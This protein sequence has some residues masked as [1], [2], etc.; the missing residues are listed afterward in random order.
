MEN[1]F[2]FWKTGP[3]LAK[4]AQI[5]KTGSN[6]AKQGQMGPSR[7]S[8]CKNSAKMGHL[9][10]NRANLDLM[11]STRANWSQRE[12]IRPCN[13]VY[14][15]LHDGQEVKIQ[16]RENEKK[17]GTRLNG[18]GFSA[19]HIDL[20]RWSIFF[21]FVRF[22]RGCS[23]PYCLTVTTWANLAKGGLTRTNEV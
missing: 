22:K 2:F 5:G 21:S 12:S 15:S 19:K 18:I 13:G 4:R 23:T 6:R 3:N 16:S 10:P 20:G 7:A 8:Q 11:G 9:G 17:Y 14:M 1:I